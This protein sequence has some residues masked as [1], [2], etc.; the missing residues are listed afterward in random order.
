VIGDVDR[1]RVCIE[2]TNGTRTEV[3]FELITKANLVFDSS[4]FEVKTGE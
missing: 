3:P 1:N 4:V 2:L